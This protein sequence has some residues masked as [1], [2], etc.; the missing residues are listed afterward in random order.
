MDGNQFDGL[1]RWLAGAQSR[2]SAVLSVLGGAVGLVGLTGAEAKHHKK[3]KKKKS[4]S[5][6]V[7]PPP[8]SPPPSPQCPASCPVCQECVN[9]QSCTSKV[10]GTA[11]ENNPCRWCQNG[12]CSNTPNDI[13]CTASNG[14]GACGNGVCN[15]RPTCTGWDSRCLIGEGTCCGGACTQ[16]GGADSPPLGTCTGSNAPSGAPCGHDFDCS[17][18]QCIG[19]R[20]Q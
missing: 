4:G 2:R 9:G 5:P 17:S 3:K 19:Y 14:P 15:S 11:C 12:T 8:V 16:D 6:P 20:C 13:A 18:H 10:N 1:L 7:S